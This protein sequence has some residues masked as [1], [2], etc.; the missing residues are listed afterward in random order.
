MLISQ[1]D[2]YEAQRNWL[3]SCIVFPV[4]PIM[5]SYAIR[6]L[7]YSPGLDDAEAVVA[8]ALLIIPVLLC[9]IALFLGALTLMGNW[10]MRSRS[11]I[12]AWLRW[13]L[14]AARGVFAVAG[15]FLF[16]LS[17]GYFVEAPPVVTYWEA[18][19]AWLFIAASII[20][21]LVQQWRRSAALGRSA[22]AA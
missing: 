22:E 7:C 11:G 5:V 17:A 12:N 19:L 8:V 6:A 15:C 21:F 3:L 14:V 18:G 9:F 16:F 10:L 13:T 1:I 2:Q 20:A 4:G